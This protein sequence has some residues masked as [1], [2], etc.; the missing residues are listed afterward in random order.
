MAKPIFCLVLL[1]EVVVAVAV[2]L[3]L[4]STRKPSLSHPLIL[5]LVLFSV[6]YHSFTRL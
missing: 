2:V 5:W 1:L 6:L 3:C 4:L